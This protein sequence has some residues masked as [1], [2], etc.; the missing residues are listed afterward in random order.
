MTAKNPA[1]PWV[2]ATDFDG[3]ITRLDVGNEIHRSL[4]PDE[5]G[6]LQATYRSGGMTLKELQ[7]QMWEN[8]A[9]NEA[10]FKKRALE[11]G[12]LRDGANHFLESC[13]DAGI[14][15]YVASCGIRTYIETVLDTMLTPKARSA[16]LGIECNRA[17]F[18]AHGISQFIPPPSS[19]ASPVPL[20]KGAWIQS[21]RREKHP[22]SKVLG[23]GNG[24]SDRSFAGQVDTLAATEALARWCEAESIPYVAFESF[25]ELLE[26]KL[27]L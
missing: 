4:K 2:V 10:T 8:F 18:S 19:P 25:Y 20:D 1:R 12:A 15:V 11:F 26:A 16:I 14:P 23:I 21:I 24:S 5:F 6:A 22:H 13:L 3:T 27:M 9:M 17:V 7:R